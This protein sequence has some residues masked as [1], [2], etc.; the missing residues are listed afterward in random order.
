MEA[1]GHTAFSFREEQRNH[2]TSCGHLFTIKARDSRE[3]EGHTGMPG[4]WFLP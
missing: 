1:L 4:L 2:R 3:E